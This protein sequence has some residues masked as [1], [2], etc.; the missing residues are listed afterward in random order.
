MVNRPGNPRRVSVL[1]QSNLTIGRPELVSS[2]VLS[3]SKKAMTGDMRS[4]A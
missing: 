2:R 1:A 4:K 3:I